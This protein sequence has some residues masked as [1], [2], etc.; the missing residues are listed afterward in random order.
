MDLRTLRHAISCHVSGATCFCA[1]ETPA[2]KQFG[3]VIV[4]DSLILIGAHV[5]R[6][7]VLNINQLLRIYYSCDW[8]IWTMLKLEKAQKIP[9]HSDG[10]VFCA[11]DWFTGIILPSRSGQWL[12]VIFVFFQIRADWAKYYF[13]Q[14]DS[15]KYISWCQQFQ[16]DV[17]SLETDVLCLLKH[18]H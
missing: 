10:V 3:R 7:D 18:L 9:L 6:F 8:K 13:H 2:R 12:R 5:W 11:H 16:M 4:P 1:C 15:L 14:Y 17:L